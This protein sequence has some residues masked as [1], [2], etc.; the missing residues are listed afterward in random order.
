[1]AGARATNFVEHKNLAAKRF[2]QCGEFFTI[3]GSDNVLYSLINI[4]FLMPPGSGSATPRRGRI[5]PECGKKP[6][7][8]RGLTHALSE[9]QTPK[10][11]R[12]IIVI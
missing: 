6:R 8:A 5:G 1:V 7:S 10:T 12:N 11:L 2:R 4:G 3:L 9:T